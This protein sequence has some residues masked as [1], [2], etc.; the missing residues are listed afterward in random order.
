MKR[1]WLLLWIVLLLCQILTAW[2]TR[3][4]DKVPPPIVSA[5]RR[6]LLELAG[7]TLREWDQR[8]FFAASPDKREGRIAGPGDLFEREEGLLQLRDLEA[9]LRQAGA[10][11]SVAAD[12]VSWQGNQSGTTGIGIG[13]ERG[14][15]YL[16]GI[17][18]WLESFLE[19]P[20]GVELERAHLHPGTRTL[21][22]SLSFELSGDP[23]SLREGLLGQLEAS[24]NWILKELDLNR[25]AEKGGWWL[26]GSCEYEGESGR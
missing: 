3:G 26:R 4:R 20:G 15:A 8:A 24:P 22:P 13:E 17:I 18:G 1:P 19:E 9:R 21:Y 16:S 10:E 7:E 25:L 2:I 12:L 6:E 14:L 11:V 23:E 5:E